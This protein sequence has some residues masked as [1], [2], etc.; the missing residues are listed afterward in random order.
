MRAVLGRRGLP[1]AP[2]ILFVGRLSREKNLPLLLQAFALAIRD[3]RDGVLVVVGD[4]PLRGR[5]ENVA[6]TLGIGERVVWA[7]AVPLRSLRGWYAASAGVVIPS[8]Q[9]GFAKVVAESCLM[10]RPVI[11]TPFVSARELLSDGVTGLNVFNA[12]T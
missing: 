7:G 2:Y 6:R 11:A 12:M 5:L 4:G 8:L 3:V 9:E 1:A 10:E